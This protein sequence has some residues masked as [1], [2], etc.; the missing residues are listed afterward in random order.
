MD[1]KR[2]LKRNEMFDFRPTGT[3]GMPRSAAY[4]FCI[5]SAFFLS[6]DTGIVENRIV[7]CFAGAHISAAASHT[8]SNDKCSSANASFDGGTQYTGL[9]TNCQCQKILM[10][11]FI[12]FNSGNVKRATTAYA[13]LLDKYE[14]TYFEH[15]AR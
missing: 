15:A 12:D 2:P 10:W 5:E 11:M 1:K 7:G 4:L 3:V 14:P 9:R 6:N 8:S 13:G